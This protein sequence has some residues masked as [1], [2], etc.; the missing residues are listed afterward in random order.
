MVVHAVDFDSGSGLAGEVVNATC[1]AQGCLVE[2]TLA[3]PVTV[4]RVMIREDIAAGQRIRRCGAACGGGGVLLLLL[5]L[6][7]WLRLFLRWR[8][9]C[10]RRERYELRTC[11]RRDGCVVLAV[12]GACVVHNNAFLVV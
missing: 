5:L 9:L 1:A 7:D 2:L 12:V 6:F 4:D 11:P 3:S 8:G 10:L